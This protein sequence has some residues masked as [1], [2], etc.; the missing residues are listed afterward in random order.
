MEKDL[1]QGM[2]EKGQTVSCALPS[3]EGKLKELTTLKHVWIIWEQMQATDKSQKGQVEKE[4]MENLQEVGELDNIVSF[5][6]LWHKVPHSNPAKF[7][8][9]YDESKQ[10]IVQPLYVFTPL[11]TI[12][13]KLAEV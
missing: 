7:F 5:W 8:T 6:Q 4:Y 1:A 9:I 11:T 3:E 13:S 10:T 12:G 2:A